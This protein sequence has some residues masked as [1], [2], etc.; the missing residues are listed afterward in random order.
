MK[1]ILSILLLL[2][3][4]V[5]SGCQDQKPVTSGPEKSYDLM[6]KTVTFVTPASPW[7]E[8]QQEIGPEE[9]ELHMPEGTVVGITFHHPDNGGLIAVGA[10]GQNVADDGEFIEI[11]N[12]QETLNQIAM[13]VEK[14]D[15]TRLKEDYIKV[16]G[17]NAFHMVFEVG[18]GERK[19]K[20][21][22]VHFTLDGH[23]YTMSMLVPLKEYSVHIDHF[24]NL[25]SSFTIDREPDA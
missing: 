5:T 11:E 24:R 21:E 17:V 6:G 22:Q 1:K 25:V 18:K 19:E 10:V 23:H 14:R 4:T 8:Q 12:D 15:G 9:A 2:F 13:W 7:V 16:L 3:I 20:G